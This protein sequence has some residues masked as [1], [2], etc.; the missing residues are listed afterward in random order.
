VRER[1]QKS[2]LD[3]D[4]LFEARKLG[5][6]ACH[7]KGVLFMSSRKSIAIGILSTAFLL[8][9]A[10]VPYPGV[11]E[12]DDVVT[13]EVPGSSSPAACIGY[14]T[15]RDEFGS[16][17]NYCPVGYAFYG[18]DDPAGAQGPGRIIAATSSCCELPSKDILTEEHVFVEE[19]CPED[20][21][22][23]GYKN[24]NSPKGSTKYMR[25][26]KINNN[27]YQLGELTPAVYWGDGASGW[28][29]AQRIDRAQIPAGIRHS[30]GRT[31]KDTW[32]VDGCVGYPWGSVFTKKTSKYCSG[33][34]FRQLQFKG[35]RGDPPA[36][37]AVKMFPDCD[38][39]QDR[40]DPNNSSCKAK[41]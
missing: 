1:T 15:S 30:M 4:V 34:F 38:E 31:S 39:L 24:W 22:A 40:N 21:I 14:N 26:S 2:P 13:F 7:K 10:G 25:C 19:S 36:G 6:R 35:L 28:R 41:S 18:V 33:L 17:Y 12:L 11:P 37:S 27:R 29:G 20:F 16:E 8:T 5:L 32:D 9:V 3:A 23:T